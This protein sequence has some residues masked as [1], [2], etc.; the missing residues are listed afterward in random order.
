MRAEDLDF[1]QI[2]YNLA[3]RDTAT[4]I[5]PL[6]MDKGIGIII[7]RPYQGGSLFREVKG[8]ALP[9]W[10]SEFGAA[11]WGQLFLKFILAHPSVTCVIPGT[12]KPEHMLDNVKA[13]FGALPS[14]QHLKK[15]IDLIS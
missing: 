9:D 14:Q 2:N 8:R 6:A 4:S 15:M 10:A 11:S 5:L 13:G 3:V 1:V 12:G 7:N